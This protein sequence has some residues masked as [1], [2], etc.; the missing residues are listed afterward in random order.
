MCS[1]DG[2]A[3]ARTRGSLRLAS[4]TAVRSDPKFAELF[5]QIWDLLRVEVIAARSA[6]GET[7]PQWGEVAQSAGGGDGGAERRE[8]GTT[9]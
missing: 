7:S 9:E 3:K 1:F 6:A 2:V 8:R 5:T 4:L